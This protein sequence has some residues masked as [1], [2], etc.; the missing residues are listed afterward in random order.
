VAA[1]AVKD[2][3]RMGSGGGNFLNLSLLER[4]EGKVKRERERE[5]ESR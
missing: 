2:G 5:R 3:S 4:L 1:A